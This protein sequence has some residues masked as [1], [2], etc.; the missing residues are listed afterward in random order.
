VELGYD[1]SIPA[2]DPTPARL[3][4]PLNPVKVATDLVAAIGEG[5]NNALV[6]IGSPPPQS[7]PAPVTL[8][9]PTADT[10]TE[11]PTKTSRLMQTAEVTRN[12][13]MSTASASSTRKVTE[14]VEADVSRQVTPTE[15]VTDTGQVTPAKK[16]AETAK[17]NRASTR[18]RAAREASANAPAPTPTPPAAQPAPRRPVVRGSHGVEEQSRDLAHRGNG[19]RPTT[20]TG[21]ADHGAAT[22]PAAPAVPN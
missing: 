19:G 13:Q 21:G 8:A 16:P 15:T 17:A 2:W 3:I 18:P 5:I 20:R 4:P 10:S 7:I 9:A 22:H 1:R 12:Q 11:T 14:T 6:A